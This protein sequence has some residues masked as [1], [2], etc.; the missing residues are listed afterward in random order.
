MLIFST[1]FNVNVLKTYYFKEKLTILRKNLLFSF[2]T[3]YFTD[4]LTILHCNAHL[5]IV[6]ILEK[7]TYYYRSL[8]SSRT[9]Y[10]SNMRIREGVGNKTDINYY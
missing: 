1:I 9:P 2:K 8:Y 5:L 6:S 4:E 3:Y 7:F 10:G